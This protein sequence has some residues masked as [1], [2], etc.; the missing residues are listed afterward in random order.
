MSAWPLESDATVA[1]AAAARKLFDISRAEIQATLRPDASSSLSTWEEIGPVGQLQFREAVLPTVWAAL[2]ALPD[3]RRAAWAEGYH[4]GVMDEF[5]GR[6]E[7]A[8]NPYP[9]A[10]EAL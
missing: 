10:E 7:A 9:Q 8:E 5:K 1:V 2:E 4:V 3:P 6:A